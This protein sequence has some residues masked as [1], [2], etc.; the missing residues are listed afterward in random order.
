M[1]LIWELRGCVCVSDERKCDAAITILTPT[2]AHILPCARLKRDASG[3]FGTCIGC[4]PL[5]LRRG[6]QGV[7]V[8]HMFGIPGWEIIQAAKP[9][10]GPAGVVKFLLL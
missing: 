7:M 9:G 3:C 1:L 6:C 4:L 10:E 8:E 2:A 5:F